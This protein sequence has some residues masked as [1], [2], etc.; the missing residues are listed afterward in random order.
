MT[1][2]RDAACKGK[3]GERLSEERWL[4]IDQRWATGIFQIKCEMETVAATSEPS[5]DDV[6]ATL[7]L[8][9]RAYDLYMRQDDQEWAR[10]S[11][12]WFGIAG[13]G[14]GKVVPIYRKPFAVIVK[15]PS[16]ANWSPTRSRDLG[17]SAGRLGSPPSRL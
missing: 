1:T 6:L 2:P 16:S 15:G 14:D 17:R 13:G 7:E 3:L 9:Q 11:G 8:S 12:C 10:C 4:E 5:M